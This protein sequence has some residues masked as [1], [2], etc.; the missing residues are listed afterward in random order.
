MSVSIFLSYPE[1]CK[2]FAKFLSNAIEEAAKE[3]GCGVSYKDWQ[4]KSF[5]TIYGNLSDNIY[6]A[7]SESTFII[8]ILDFPMDGRFEGKGTLGEMVTSM[9]L[10]KIFNW[11]NGDEQIFK[12]MAEES[13]KFANNLFLELPGIKHH[14]LRKLE[15]SIKSA[16][17]YYLACK[18]YFLLRKI[19]E[20][21]WIEEFVNEVFQEFLDLKNGWAE[22][23]WLDYDFDKGNKEVLTIE[24]NTIEVIKIVIGD[25]FREIG[26]AGYQN[27]NPEGEEI[28]NAVNKA[29]DSVLENLEVSEEIKKGEN[30]MLSDTP[31]Q[32]SET[33][34]QKEAEDNHEN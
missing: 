22:L 19:K 4:R 28:R 15:E 18:T 6:K 12:R 11:L 33:L 30:Y 16:F 25:I 29:V 9:K 31:K 2:S 23:R 32:L 3:L 34:Q 20:N 14:L 10:R 17:D 21:N 8:H 26:S 24:K 13:L 27:F 1:R 7:M 5:I